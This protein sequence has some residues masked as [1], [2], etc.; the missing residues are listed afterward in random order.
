MRYMP[1][2]AIVVCVALIL[3]AIVAVCVAAQS[4]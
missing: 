1:H 2:A 4:I 3:W